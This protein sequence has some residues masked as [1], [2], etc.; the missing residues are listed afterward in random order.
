[1][2][3]H[4]KQVSIYLN[5]YIEQLSIPLGKMMEESIHWVHNCSQLPINRTQNLVRLKELAAVA[6]LKTNSF[7][8]NN[9]IFPPEVKVISFLLG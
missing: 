7:E 3:P 4:H 8:N 5:I 2:E 1:M 6:T 9:I